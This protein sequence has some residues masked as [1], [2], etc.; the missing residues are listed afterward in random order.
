[1]S[2]VVSLLF[3]TVGGLAL[4]AAH[5]GGLWVCSGVTY[6]LSTAVITPSGRYHPPPTTIHLQPSSKGGRTYHSHMLVWLLLL[7]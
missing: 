2:S 1:M 5:L 3:L 7:W 6:T 4:F